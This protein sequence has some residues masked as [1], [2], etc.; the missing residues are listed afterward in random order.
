MN[1]IYG[2]VSVPGSTPTVINGIT[3]PDRAPYE[4]KGLIVWTDV[5]CEITIKFNTATIGGG[6]VTG[7]QPTL[8]IDFSS[9]P[10]GI[11]PKDVVSVIATHE[12]TVA[13]TVKSTLLVEQL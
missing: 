4:L 11:N 2:D 1:N 6:C 13:H 10:Y 5:A 7:A 3:G 9:S 8:F 12:D